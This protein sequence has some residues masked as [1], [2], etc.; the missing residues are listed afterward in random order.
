MKKSKNLTLIST[1]LIIVILSIFFSKK[2]IAQT[3]NLLENPSF[4]NGLESWTISESDGNGNTSIEVSGDTI[5]ITNEEFAD[6]RIGQMVT[7]EPNSFYKISAMIKIEDAQ[8]ETAFVAGISVGGTDAFTYEMSDTQ[9]E[10][11]PIELVVNTNDYLEMQVDFGLGWYQQAAKGKAT[12]KDVSV[13]KLDVVDANAEIAYLSELGFS[14]V[15]EEEAD[16]FDDTYFIVSMFIICFILVALLYFAF[17][18]GEKSD[19]LIKTRNIKPY[20]LMLIALGVVARL[21]LLTKTQGYTIDV[22]CFIGWSRLVVEHGPSNFYTADFFSDYPPG[23]MYLLYF[24]GWIN[25]VLKINPYSALG[26]VIVFAPAWISD[27]ALC[28]II[29]NYAKKKNSEYFAMLMSVLIL[30]N[31]V[32]LYDTAVWQQVDSVLILA[33]V[34]TFMMLDEKKYIK[35]SIAFAIAVLLKPQAL[36]AGPVFALYY[37]APLFKKEQRKKAIINM[38]AALAV[39]LGIIFICSLPFKG[40]QNLFW[41]VERYYNTG[42]QYPYASVNAFN[43]YALFGANWVGHDNMLLFLTYKQWGI[44]GIVLSLVLTVWFFIKS[45]KNKTDNIFLILAFFMMSIFM[46]AHNMHERYSVPVVILLIFAYIKT[47]DKGILNSFFFVSVPILVNL[48]L[49]L[50]TSIYGQLLESAAFNDVAVKVDSLLMLASWMYLT[51]TCYDI[52]VLGKIVG[53]KK[54]SEEDGKIILPDIY[55]RL[56]KSEV[57]IKLNGKDKSFMIGITIVYAVIALFNLGTRNF[58]QSYWRVG[59]NETLSIGFEEEKN[60]AQIWLNT[61]ISEIDLELAYGE[62]ARVNENFILTPDEDGMYSD[63][64]DSVPMTEYAIDFNDMYRWKVIDLNVITD[65]IDFTSLT[66]DNANRDFWINEMVFVGVDGEIIAPQSVNATSNGKDTRS[67]ISNI[68]DEQN[69]KPEKPNAQNGMYFDELYH[70]RTAF[71]HLNG[72]RVYETTHPPLGKIFIM[73]GIALFG[74]NPFGWRIVGTVFGIAMVP[75]FYMLAKRLFKKTNICM[76]TTVLFTFD[77]MH[78]VQTRIATIDVYGVFFILLMYYYMLEY[79]QMSFFIHDLKKTLRPLLLSGLFFGLGA[80]SKWICLYAGAGLAIIFFGSILMRVSEYL[81]VREL[82]K[83]YE[84]I[85]DNDESPEKDRT[86]PIYELESSNLEELKELEKKTRNLIPNIVKTLVFCLFAFIILPCSIYFLS[87]TPFFLATEADYGIKSFFTYQ[88]HMFNYHS[89]LTARHSFESKALTWMLDI[90]PI[91]YYQGRML[92]DNMRASIAAFGNPVVWWSGLVGIVSAIAI[93]FSDG[94]RNK[95]V[96]FI[97]VAFA[98][99]FVPWLFVTRAIFI[100][101]YFASVPFIIL[102][103]GYL[104]Y[105]YDK[106]ATRKRNNSIMIALS[107]AT[108]ALF[109]F[110]YP[111]MNGVTITEQYARAMIW[112]KTWQFYIV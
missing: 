104:F 86:T 36:V 81:R 10:F 65:K 4:S 105:R 11:I 59:Q 70:A 102:A 68:F 64:V 41:I 96:W 55:T 95:R 66:N 71:E 80:A 109:V 50:S 9:D 38:F 90:R 76:F 77:I 39:S 15:E 92:A 37:I 79:L 49:V 112:F 45:N 25:Q 32:L 78:F 24:V 46:F 1:V 97:V 84:S 108:I 51:F 100:Y 48:V 17:K 110:F 20:L 83:K 75:I 93:A 99:Q 12:F 69:T 27:I 13:T 57:D 26:Q 29:F 34:A 19:S 6:A 40:T 63:E 107:V 3:D 62:N 103:L 8:A 31:P 43:I 91:W 94:V 23:Y 60:I 30:F 21:I 74:M 22:N 28:F 111:V 98:S 16:P 58:P 106:H 52:F 2:G 88:T 72:L 67:D 82:I 42:V 18:Q 85:S 89:Q 54:K 53:R 56:N 47:K 101:H 87:Y 7:V 5:T 35:A 61:G 33:L 14:D 44:L 73:I